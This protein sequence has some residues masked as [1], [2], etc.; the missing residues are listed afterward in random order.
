M[1]EQTEAALPLVGTRLGFHECSSL[2]AQLEG[3]RQMIP[4][5]LLIAAV[6]RV[7]RLHVIGIFPG[8]LLC[9]A[10]DASVL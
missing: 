1:N 9:F 7:V 3:S 6:Q 10:L 5:A 2:R 4:P 8:G